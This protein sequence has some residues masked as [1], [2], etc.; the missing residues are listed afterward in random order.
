MYAGV[1]ATW[2]CNG[3]LG[4]NRRPT[5]TV[6]HL[7]GSMRMN[8]CFEKSKT[9]SGALSLDNKY[10]TRISFDLLPSKKGYNNIVHLRII[11]LVILIIYGHQCGK[12]FRWKYSR[13]TLFIQKY[14]LYKYNELPIS[15]K[16]RNPLSAPVSILF[17]R[18]SPVS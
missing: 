10:L 8:K 14:H 4:R 12:P 1:M 17:Y 5:I 2:K 16:I 15:S 18:Q 6:E 9:L 11:C 7:G 3:H 13:H